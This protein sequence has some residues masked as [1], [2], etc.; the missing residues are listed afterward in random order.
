M[1]LAADPEGPIPLSACPACIAAPAAEDLARR[2][3]PK[4]ARLTLSIPEAHCAACISTV[5]KGLEKLEGVKSARVNLTLKRVFVEADPGIAAADLIAPL[6][7]LGYEAHELDP[8]LL[9]STENDRKGRELIMRIGIS[10]F[11]MM[12]V[13][14]LSVAVWVGATD[15][16]RDMF[17]TIAGLI[18][19]PTVIFCAQP[20]FKSA[21]DGLKAGRVVMDFPIALAMVLGCAISIFETLNSGP[22]AY[23]DG[24]VMLTF[25]LL[26]G[27]WL[28]HRTR[29][30]ARSA[31]QELAAL[32]V[33][34]AIRLR[35]GVEETVGIADLAKG[36]L[37]LV[38]PGGRMPV[39]GEIVAGTSE[40]DRSLLTGEVLPVFA[41]PGQVVSAGE[42]NLTGP[43]TVRVEAAGRDS[44]LSRMAEL[45]AVA[46][47]AKTRYTGLA[48]AAARLYAPVVHT[49]AFG[50][51]MAWLWISGGDLRL[52]VNIAAGTLIITCPC[53]LG[54]AVPAVLTAASGRL[55]K[56]GLLIKSGTALERMAAVD[57]VLFDKTGTL[58]MGRPEPVNFTDH[59]AEVLSVVAGLTGASSHPLALSL[60]ARSEADGIAPLQI[61][62][63]RE[64]PGFGIEGLLDGLRV[65]LGRAAWVGAEERAETATYLMLPDGSTHAFTFT[66]AL[67]PGAEEL[68]STLQSRGLTVKLI[69]G[70]TPAA[71]ASLA[72]R[73]GISDWAAEARPE[74]KAA[75]VERLRDAGRHV[76]MVGDGLNDTAA[77]AAAHASISPSTALD[78]ARVASDIVLLSKDLTP[79]AEALRLSK[80]ATRRMQE[81]FVISGAYN[82]IAVPVALLGY[83]SPL[84]AAVAM[85]LSS[86]TVALNALRTR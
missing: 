62:D 1:S 21:W 52:A 30:M 24:I 39:D 59:S 58:T 29:A 23:F 79:V 15:A 69:S 22:H 4:A 26:I 5:E 70:D 32:E 78:A 7:T 66:D 74:D 75:E 47:T 50:A 11:A 82:V 36:D 73:L 65:R 13:N 25:F 57:T 20:F 44:S 77:L 43:L 19:I 55:F 85:S 86:I 2:A 41:A 27:R 3:Q 72:G 8:G 38:R 80:V 18:A 34:R 63:L 64:V 35:E 45:V 17:H 56:L 12:N 60:R 68:I 46:E 54:L 31:A 33:P 9:S 28:D 81:N 10:G 14:L 84:W 48:D 51:F 83:A 42:V 71:V 67:R 16:T 49:L 37:V 40:L 61:S 76:L 53:A 6:K